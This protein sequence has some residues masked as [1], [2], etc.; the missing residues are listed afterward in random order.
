MP[1]LPGGMSVTEGCMKKC[2]TWALIAWPEAP[3]RKCE[4][5]PSRG[6]ACNAE[7]HYTLLCHT[8]LGQTQLNVTA[9]IIWLILGVYA[10]TKSQENGIYPVSWWEVEMKRERLTPWVSKSALGA[11][12]IL[13]L[14]YFQ[15]S[16]CSVQMWRE[17]E[18]E[19]MHFLQSWSC[20]TNILT[21]AAQRQPWPP[22]GFGEVLLLSAQLC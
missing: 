4:M 7:A 10:W 17:G 5:K 14:E 13:I 6:P 3:I 21:P 16:G 1:I 22:D 9:I 2:P 12:C 8:S 18:R 15:G 19:L 11:Y 20:R